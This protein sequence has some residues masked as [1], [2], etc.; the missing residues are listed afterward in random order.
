MGTMITLKASDGFTLG[1]YEAKPEG[2]PRAGLVVIQEIFGVNDH[3]KRVADGFADDGYHVISPA[4]F[5]RGERGVDLG[6][7][8]AD[9]DKGIAI[10]GKIPL[11]A[12]LLDVAAAIAALKGAGKVAIVG[13]CFGGSLAW[14]GAT[15]LDGLSA[16]IG[17]YGGMIANHLDE[18]PR[19]PI[20]LHFG[21]QDGGIP[22][23]DVDKIRAASDPAKVQIF[24]YPAG[25]A[26]NRDGTPVY[27]AH[28]A[29][30]ARM[31]TL[32]FL[33]EQVG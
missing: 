33:Q 23:T 11:E 25:H 31:R 9:I 17:Y 13:Y 7:D 29:M 10:R 6:Y 15:R 27:S 22:M 32:K 4:I 14:L 16:T 12:T 5:D 26:F 3:I 20:M 21:E 30:L 19:C 24:T 18:K 8:K 2:K 1:A 28:C